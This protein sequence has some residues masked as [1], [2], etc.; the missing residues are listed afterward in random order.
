MAT[1]RRR[2]PPRV[3]LCSRRKH[4]RLHMGRRR[5]CAR[6]DSMPQEKVRIYLSST[7]YAPE[8]RACTPNKT[9]R[10]PIPAALGRAVRSRGTQTPTTSILHLV[11]ECWPTVH[12]SP[13]IEAS[14]WMESG[15]DSAYLLPSS[16]PPTPPSP[17][18]SPGATYVRSL[19]VSFALHAGSSSGDL[20]CSVSTCALRRTP[21]SS[22]SYAGMSSTQVALHL[23]PT[24]YHRPLR[25]ALAL[26]PTPPL[27]ARWCI[28]ATTG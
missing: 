20:L 11:L 21:A 17:F 13:E 18:P 24:V 27:Q 19:H 2:R 1:L 3:L 7:L 12:G 5:Q 10:A 25:R 26:L 6:L 9:M 22:S 15:R 23:G 28:G 14:R 4:R 8:S 16:S